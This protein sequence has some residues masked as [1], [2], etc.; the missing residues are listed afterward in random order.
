MRLAPTRGP[1]PRPDGRRPTCRRASGSPRRTSPRASPP[2]RAVPPPGTPPSHDAD[3]VVDV[4]RRAMRL[5][6]RPRSRRPSRRSASNGR[7]WNAGSGAGWSR[8]PAHSTPSPAYATMAAAPAAASVRAV[9]VRSPHV[10]GDNG[11]RSP[12]ARCARR[13]GRARIDH[14]EGALH[15]GNRDVPHL[16]RC[17]SERLQGHG[18]AAAEVKFSR[19]LREH[20]PEPGANCALASTRVASRRGGRWPPSS[21]KPAAPASPVQSTSMNWPSVHAGRSVA[22][23]NGCAAASSRTTVVF[24]C[25]SI[26]GW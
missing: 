8:S 23:V 11:D 12:D 16:L 13:R 4:L 21:V 18:T 1:C 22:V 3:Q 17:S 5:E 7:A 25:R 24:S 2:R 9:S 6:L 19:R 15:V 20:P 10:P 26:V 14:T